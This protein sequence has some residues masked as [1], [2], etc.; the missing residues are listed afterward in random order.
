MNQALLKLEVERSPG[1]CLHF[2]TLLLLCAVPER[3]ELG[4]PTCAIFGNYV[5]ERT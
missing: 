4:L 3:F 1:T 5:L 2:S